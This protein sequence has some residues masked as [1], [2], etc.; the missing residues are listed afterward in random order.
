MKRV[1]AMDTTRIFS[2]P[3]SHFGPV[4]DKAYKIEQLGDNS[5]HGFFADLIDHLAVERTGKPSPWSRNKTTKKPDP[6]ILKKALIAAGITVPPAT[7]WY[8]F[9]NRER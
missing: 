9:K 3:A 2:S 1:D 5:Y 8:Y 6:R 4:N 7:V